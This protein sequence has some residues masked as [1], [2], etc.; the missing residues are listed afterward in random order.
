MAIQNFYCT[1]CL[2]TQHFTP[3]LK[4]GSADGYACVRCGHKLVRRSN[5]E[6]RHGQR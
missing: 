3:I 5:E 1:V 2:Q 4:P 6:E